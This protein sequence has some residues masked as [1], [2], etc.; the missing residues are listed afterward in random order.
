ME[1]MSEAYL[2]ALCAVNGFSMT[3]P[4]NDNEGKFMDLA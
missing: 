4:S 1:H 3:P 2:E